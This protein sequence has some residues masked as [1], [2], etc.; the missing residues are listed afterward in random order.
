MPHTPVAQNTRRNA[1]S[2]RRVMT[3]PE[4]KLWNALRAHRL[5]GLSFRRQVPIAGYIADFACPLKKLIVEVDGSQHGDRMHAHGDQVRTRRLEADGWTVLRF[6]NDDVLTDLEGVCRHIV[7]AAG[8]GDAGQSF[9]AMLAG[10]VLQPEE[11][12]P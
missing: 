5:M 12:R 3:E 4:L 1:K 6:W 8:V 11:F 2:M 7:V 10:A 9:D